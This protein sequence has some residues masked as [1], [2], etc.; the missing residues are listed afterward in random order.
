M[1]LTV[2]RSRS[3][4]IR[5]LG[6]GEVGVWGPAGWLALGYARTAR[7]QA[8]ARTAAEDRLYAADMNRTKEPIEV[9]VVE[10]RR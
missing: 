4:T 2:T 3:R 7:E 10:M 8:F 5:S 1:T 6:G 9:I